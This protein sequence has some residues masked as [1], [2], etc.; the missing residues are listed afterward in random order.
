MLL[1][2][3]Q[4]PSFQEVRE[5]PAASI[6]EEVR[7]AVAVLDERSELEVFLRDVLF[8]PNETPHGPAEIADIF[9]H[10]VA[11]GSG[12]VLAAFILKGRSFQ[13]VRPSHVSHQ[14]YRL[15][16]ITDLGLAVFAAVGTVLDAAKEQFVSVASRLQVDYC[17]MDAV[18]IG[19][20]LLAYGFLCPRDGRQIRGGRCGCGYSPTARFTNV[21]Q[22]EAIAELETAHRLK[23]RAGLVVLPTGS[24]KTRIAAR[25]SLTFGARRI[26]YLAHTNEILNIA[27]KEFSAVFGD[28]AIHHIRP[29]RWPAQAA[30]VNLSTIQMARQHAADLAQWRCDY[31]VVDEFHHAAAASYRT[32][33]EAVQPGFVL[34]LTATPF[35]E[36]RRDI[37]ALCEGNVVVQHE[38]RAGI[39]TGILCPYHYYGS[40]DDIDYSNLTH[41][42]QQYTIRDLE[43]ALVVP[44]RDAAIVSKWRERADGL[45]T[46]AFCCSQHHAERVAKSFRDAGIEA[47]PYIAV[48][49]L[50]ERSDRLE[51]LRQGD[52]KVLTTVDVL[53]EGA[54]MPFVECLL[55]LRPTESKR[56]FLQQ[57]GRGLR[58]SVGKSRCLVIDFIG[59]FKNAYRIAEYQ[60]L[61]PFETD[62]VRE[63]TGR[64]LSRKEVLN[65]P[66]GCQVQFDD[67]V[68]DL[69]ARQAFDPRSA[70]RENIAR[71]LIYQLERT[72]RLLGR[73]PTRKDVDR[74][75][76]LG[77][78][79]YKLV[80]GGLPPLG[81]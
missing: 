7:R 28:E 47:E 30:A 80:F 24:G 76:L 60:G 79:L 72:E 5:W 78:D 46:L 31:V 37:L 22:E 65:L 66:L 8:D 19:R 53:N 69:F 18:D 26:L 59:N 11:L 64:P 21:L 33:L 13:T 55:F 34:G 16:K 40:F 10:R 29:G 57:L 41:K 14:I 20:V 36:D 39:D 52:L 35:R 23:Q 15:E 77:M 51:R 62:E 2:V 50:Q 43:R 68:V 54:D 42:G 63:T 45:P 56:I 1:T 67:R 25:D 44:A 6:G 71:I 70:T 73:P 49:G 32:V 58:R 17:W 38:L 9:T 4:I 61:T 27:K 75:C 12:P 74:S 48:T 81:E 3:D